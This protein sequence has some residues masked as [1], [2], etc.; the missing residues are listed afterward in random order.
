MIFF[1]KRWLNGKYFFSFSS[2]RLLLTGY[3]HY[4]QIDLN[5]LQHLYIILLIECNKMNIK[6]FLNVT[7]LSK[8]TLIVI[9][10]PN[11]PIF[12]WQ[13]LESKFGCCWNILLL[14]KT[15][16][17]YNTYIKL[18]AWTQFLTLPKHIEELLNLFKNSKH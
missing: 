16:Q 8:K 14:Q 18:Q 13:L 12:T 1:S 17:M 3:G 7:E 9:Y 5:K 6:T 11:K 4:T 15:M 2:F 10:L